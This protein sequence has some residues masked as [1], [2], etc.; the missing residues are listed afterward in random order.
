M[1]QAAP[2]PRGWTSK[3]TRTPWPRARSS[4]PRDCPAP[5]PWAKSTSRG[6][7]STPGDGLA[8]WRA[9]R[10]IAARRPCWRAPGSWYR[11]AVVL[12]R[13]AVVHIV[14]RHPRRRRADS[15]THTKRLRS[16]AGVPPPPG[17]TRRVRRAISVAAAC[18]QNQ[19]RSRAAISSRDSAESLKR[20]LPQSVLGAHVQHVVEFPDIESV[21][22]AASW[23]GPS[24][25][26]GEDEEGSAPQIPADPQKARHDVVDA[27]RRLGWL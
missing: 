25:E 23:Q 17:S 8:S 20:E 13:L 18:G 5:G 24:G 16:R 9:G 10:S 12:D 3:M 15:L 7:A 27:P 26:T 14:G 11:G 22:V 1:G 19:P 6:R 4:T 21:V 2:P